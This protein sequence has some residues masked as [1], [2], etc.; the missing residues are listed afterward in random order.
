MDILAQLLNQFELTLHFQNTGQVANFFF[1]FIPFVLFLELPLYALMVFGALRY[2]IYKDSIPPIQENYYPA[3]TCIVICYSE[4]EMV[5]PTILSIAEQLY[6][7]HVEIIVM[8]D[9]ASRNRATLDA[10]RSL[11]PYVAR[12]PKRTLNVVPKWQRGG[13]V[14]SMNAGLRLASGDVTIAMDGDTSFENRM[15][16]KAVRHFTDPRVLGVSGNLRVRNARASLITRLQAIEY[17]ITINLARTGMSESN[18]VNN[19]SGAFGIFRT[20]ALRLV[21]GWDSGTAEDLDLTLRLKKHFGRRNFLIRFEP[22]SIGF[23]DVPETLKDL[24]K[25]R[26]RWDGDLFYLYMRKHGLSFTPRIMGLRNFIMLLWYG[27]LFQLVQPFVIVGYTVYAAA[28]FTFVHFLFIMTIVYGFYT[29][30]SLTLY[31]ANI[32]LVSSYKMND[33]KLLPFIPMMPAYLLGS[34]LWSAFA[35]L[36]E[37]VTKGHMQSNMAPSWVLKK[38]KY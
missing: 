29:I 20:S 32:L 2:Y 22:E 36:W 16:T 33:L 26:L 35:T 34:R 37:M 11:A 14:S 6:P 3:V 25:Q 27:L 12:F 4:G 1:K 24:L 38:T 10:A 15:L 28:T 17:G 9:G 7:G 21:N 13:R 5:K 8:V 18:T 31:L 23:T 30:L 19:I